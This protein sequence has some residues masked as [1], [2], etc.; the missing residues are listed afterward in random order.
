MPRTG[1]HP[2]KTK[3]FYNAPV[4]HRM[5]TVTTIVHIPM[6]SGYW[7]QSLNVLKLCIDS[8]Y[9]NTGQPFDLMVFDNGSCEEVRSYLLELKEKGRIQYLVLSQQNLR[10]LEAL[11]F[12]LSSS[13]GEYIAYADSD[14]YFLPGWLD[15]SIKVLKAF[16]KAGKVTALPIIGGDFTQDASIIYAQARQDDTVSIEMGILVPEMYVN[17]H[18]LSL[19]VADEN[20]A[21]RTQNRRDVLLR[22]N[23]CE[24]YLAGADFQFTITRRA[25]TAALPLHIESVAEYFDPIYSPVLERR[26]DEAGFWQLSTPG[27]WVHH[28]GNHVPELEKELT[29]LNGEGVDQF[30]SL[31]PSQ[32]AGDGRKTGL[33]AYF[34]QNRAVR[35]MLKKIHLWTYRLLYP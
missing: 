12:L 31:K 7:Q 6:L 27:Y 13:P 33:K 25:A 28:M 29:W 4:V 19:G 34:L 32:D 3:D 35:G 23:G 17:A 10:K 11:N 5:V 22:R 14:V 16:P 15:E 26:L 2:L 20:Y 1:R 9:A 21:R 18:R 30:G 24:A 8:L